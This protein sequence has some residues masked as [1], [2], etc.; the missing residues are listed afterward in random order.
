MSELNNVIN[1]A[2]ALADDALDTAKSATS[3]SEGVLDQAIGKGKALLGKATDD[4]SLQAEGVIDQVSGK[5]KSVASDL[6]DKAGD[7]LDDLKSK[8]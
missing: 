4:K 1:K 5:A 7:L 6:A 8:L 3:K 2:K